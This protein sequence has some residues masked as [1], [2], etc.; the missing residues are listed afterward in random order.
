M[1]KNERLLSA[2][3]DVRDEY[4]EEAVHA[5]RKR[6]V[7]WKAIAAAAAC[8]CLAAGVLM[9]GLFG[10][11]EAL[12]EGYVDI[13]YLDENSEM[14][15]EPVYTELLQ[16]KILTAWAEKNNVADITVMNET[17]D[18][19]D[20]DA[21]GINMWVTADSEFFNDYEFFTTDGEQG[22]MVFYIMTLSVVPDDLKALRESFKNTI[23]GCDALMISVDS[24]NRFWM[25]AELENDDAEKV[26][27]WYFVL[28]DGTV[29][30]EDGN[31][32]DFGLKFE[33]ITE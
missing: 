20:D 16:E 8:V 15:S 32:T 24:E 13:Y 2:I 12:A 26:A 1:K 5:P 21:I 14:T 10:G 18:A 23:D 11:H 27:Q 30:D 29:V 28:P 6:S 7:P 31:P 19:E 3:G 9:A 25:I 17:E 4:I 22:D 33:T